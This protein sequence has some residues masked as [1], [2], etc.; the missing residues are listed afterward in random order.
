MGFGHD[1]QAAPDVIAVPDDDEAD[2]SGSSRTERH[3]DLFTEC[4]PVPSPS[5]QTQ[6]NSHTAPG[7]PTS[8]S[9]SSCHVHSSPCDS[10]R[11]I[12]VQSP[13]ATEVPISPSPRKCLDCPNIPRRKI[14]LELLIPVG[15]DSVRLDA[16]GDDILERLLACG[17][18]H[19]QHILPEDMPLKDVTTAWL[20]SH[21]FHGEDYKPV[22]HFYTDG[23]AKVIDDRSAWAC[24]VASS[25]SVED[26][27]DDF[28]Y[29]GWFSGETILDENHLHHLGG[30]RHDSVTCEAT[31]MFWAL[32]FALAHHSEVAQCVFHFDALSVGKAMDASFNL[33]VAHPIVGNLR[34]LMQLAEALFGPTCIHTRHVKGHTGHPLNELVNNIAF[35]AVD[36]SLH[37]P[38]PCDL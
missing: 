20:A 38:H 22:L 13:P 34:L 23:S 5:V 11:V 24:A 7:S 19:L 36:R 28:T 17:G 6:A 29:H 26:L 27:A 21:H 2:D 25:L 9:V 3:E 30:D 12:C 16:P 18:L 32:L 33:P 10:Q 1:H 14:S 37:E 8:H 31:G 35:L 15:E 4:G